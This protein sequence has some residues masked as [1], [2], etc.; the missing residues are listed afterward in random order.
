MTAPDQ[1]AGVQATCP[2]CNQTFRVPDASTAS[3]QQPEQP[4]NGQGKR[5]V[6]KPLTGVEILSVA[7]LIV[8]MLVMLV[9]GLLGTTVKSWDGSEVHNI[10]L[11]AN[12]LTLALIGA[13]S[14]TAGAILI[15]AMQRR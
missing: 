6:D 12:K 14:T 3:P 4:E 11:I 2:K 9:A 7:L 1:K 8:G 10:G 15:A 13:G 5:P